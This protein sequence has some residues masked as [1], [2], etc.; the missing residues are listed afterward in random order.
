[1]VLLEW[2]IRKIPKFTTRSQK[3]SGSSPRSL[4][5]SL[6]LQVLKY[7]RIVLQ[8]KKRE[9]VRFA[10]RDFRLNNT[11][12]MDFIYFLRF[13]YD[14]RAINKIKVNYQN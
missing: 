9:I 2:F 4:P 5:Y 13:K 12:R 3:K 14:R 8:E 6:F 11:I 10:S 7:H 1:M